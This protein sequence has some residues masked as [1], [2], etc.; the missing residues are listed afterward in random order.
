MIVPDIS[1]PHCAGQRIKITF[2][3]KSVIKTVISLYIWLQDH[4]GVFSLEEGSGRGMKERINTGSCPAKF[5][6]IRIK[7]NYASRAALS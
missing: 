3:A 5:P 4:H 2:C 6:G 7:K 1:I